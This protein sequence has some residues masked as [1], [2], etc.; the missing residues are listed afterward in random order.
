VN[1]GWNKSNIS[2]TYKLQ[3]LYILQKLTW[4]SSTESVMMP[5]TA[6]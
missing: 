4:E 6:V 1:K 3:K 2:T 5:M